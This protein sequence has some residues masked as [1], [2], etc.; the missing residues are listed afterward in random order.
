[1]AKKT[2]LTMSARFAL[3][4]LAGEL[5][6]SP[7]EDK[8]VKAAY[9]KAAPLVRSIVETKYPPKDMRVLQK[10][11]KAQKDDCIKLQLAAGGIEVFNFAGNTGP[12][13]AHKTYEG[14]IYPADT[15]ATDAVLEWK[16]A[17]DARTA[18]RDQKIADYKTLI[19]AARNL[20]DVTAIW[21]EAEKVRSQ[22]KSTALVVLS[23]DVVTRIQADVATRKK[24]A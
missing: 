24:A 4:K 2:R 11:K 8:A 16:K 22:L 9:K 12:M 21:P 14:V 6:T 20:E 17:V 23:P 1:M 7:D 5:V 10:Y 3:K 13:V 15:I 18:A 19:Y